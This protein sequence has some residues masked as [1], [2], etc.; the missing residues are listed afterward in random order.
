MSLRLVLSV[1]SSGPGAGEVR[2]G[3]VDSEGPHPGRHSRCYCEV[4]EMSMRV[5]S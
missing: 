3:E 4:E 5:V 1:G 2:W